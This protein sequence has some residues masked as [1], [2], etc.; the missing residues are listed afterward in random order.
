MT[1]PKHAWMVRA[2]DNNEL[3][4][5]VE[6][7]NAV[8]IG[9]R[10]MGDMSS[11]RTRDEFKERVREVYP[12]EST[13]QASSS[14]G[15]TLRFVCQMQEGDYV[16]T[17]R[18]ATRELLIGALTGQYEHNPGL[19]PG[20]PHVRRVSWLKT[21]SRDDF[22]TGARNSLGSLL[23]V[24]NVDAHLD[25]IHRLAMGSPPPEEEE[26]EGP[27]FYEEVKAR[28]DELIADRISRLDPYEFQDL[29]AGVLR[30]MGFRAVSASPGPDRGVDIVAHR[31][32]FGFEGPRIKAQVKHRKG[33]VGA[34][35]MRAFVATL[36]SGD[37]GLYISTGGFTRE[38]ETEAERSRERVTRLDRDGL[39]RLLLEHYETLDP[40][41]KAQV[42]LRRVWLPAE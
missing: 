18:K 34:Q 25:E 16:L 1:K 28:A 42:P 31:D 23:S 32:P 39:I 40:E 5:L 7:K 29:V 35:E 33:S 41:Y 6:Q 22:S 10:K 26:E 11:F 15:Q 13:R 4:D 21:V 19:L 20:Y 14:A 36:R 24:F 2:G 9:W 27:P 17:Y 30:A 3:A 12:D 37:N 8:A 38:A